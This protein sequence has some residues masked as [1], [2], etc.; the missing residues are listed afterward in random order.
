MSIKNRLESVIRGW[1]PKEPNRSRGKLKMAETKA[2]KTKPWLWTHWTLLVAS[3]IVLIGVQV[4]LFLLSYI[5]LF[6]LFGGVLVI[7]LS[8]PLSYTIGYIQT[9]YQQSKS[10][11]LTN[12]IAFILGP[13]CL[14]VGAALFS[15]V[16]ISLA[17]GG[18]SANYL[19]SMGTLIIMYVIAPSIG[20]SLGYL[21]GKKRNFMPYV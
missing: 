21:I 2:S 18:A 15:L 9:R 7:L 4:V 12:K 5:E 17:T 20:G 14:A 11:Q 6:T 16:F 3:F 19:G 10:V 1:F 13:A 8:I